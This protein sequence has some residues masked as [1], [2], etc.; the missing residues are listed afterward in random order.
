MV[1]IVAVLFLNVAASA[2]TPA[3]VPKPSETPLETAKRL[4]ASKELKDRAQ[5]LQWLKA[6]AKPGITHGD[7]ALTRY[8]DLCLRF[9]A[10]GDKTTLSEAKRAFTELKEKFSGWWAKKGEVGLLRVAAAEGKREEAMKGLDWFLTTQGK[11]DPFIEAAFYLGCLYADAKDDLKQLELAKKPFNYALRLLAD[12]KDYYQGDLTEEMIREKMKWL[13]TRI[14]ELKAGPIKLAFEKAERLRQ[15]G[16]F[17][18]AIPVYEWIVKEDP[19]HILAECS[20][21]RI[22]Q[23]L[24]GLKK[25]PEA[26]K[27]LG[28]FVKA[29]PLGAYR[30]HAHLELGDYWLEQEFR[31]ACAEVEYNAILHP[32]K[33]AAPDPNK[34]PDFWKGA[35]DPKIFQ[36]QPDTS[37]PNE[38]PLAA[39][40]L[41]S[42]DPARRKAL[43]ATEIPKDAHETWSE[44]IPDA[45]IRLGI[46]TYMRADFKTADRHF[47]TSY[48]MRPDERF[49]RGIPSGMLLL[50]EK[51]RQREMPLPWQ[52]LA[53]GGDRPRVCL[54]LASAYLEGSKFDKAGALFD[55]VVRSDF[56]EAHAEQVAYALCQS[57]EV[58]WNFGD[59]K[60]AAL[61]W[62][63]FLDKPYKG[64]LIA[65]R[66]ILKLGCTTFTATQDSRDLDLITRVYREYPNS[67]AA[68]LA[69]F[70]HASVIWDDEP[71]K[72]L[73]LLSALQRNY[74]QN[75]HSQQI[76]SLMDDCRRRAEFLRRWQV[77]Q[78]HE[79]TGESS[80]FRR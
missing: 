66:A 32:E 19:E 77:E 61:V 6:L 22:G 62:R 28:E 47:S 73:A 18:E 24:F 67:D 30:G 38:D 71:E 63:K 76:F 42:V 75:P 26:V 58:L 40:A 48:Q 9:H 12:Q 56:K 68:P 65:P 13:N 57:G 35:I 55:R 10:E 37:I 60:G 31:A 14:R 4:A 46:V 33:Y 21:L 27:H 50:A 51:C 29:K 36:A 5:A 49:G 8:G 64:T 79:R 2:A 70:Q 52:L 41:Q 20:G 72:A 25:N 16:K 69:L 34:T 17:Q 45:H 78:E 1:L 74:P 53:V 39:E 3:P 23:C 44:V 11:D 54:F 15:A 43:I 80:A 59:G 7:E